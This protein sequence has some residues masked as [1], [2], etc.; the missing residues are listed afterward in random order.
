MTCRLCQSACADDH[1]HLCAR[2]YNRV[3]DYDAAAPSMSAAE[4]DTDRRCEL[5]ERRMKG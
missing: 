4:L 5:N 2:C 1:S 3:L